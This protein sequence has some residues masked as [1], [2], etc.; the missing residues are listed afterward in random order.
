MIVL[1]ILAQHPLPQLGIQ[2]PIGRPPTESMHQTHVTTLRQTFLQA[3]HLPNREAE[4]LRRLGL[5]V[6]PFLH[7]MQNFESITFTLPHLDPVSTLHAHSRIL[8]DQWPKRTFLL[9]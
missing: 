8:L 4:Q 2:L 5:S 9:R 1:A 6:L 7:T 3:P